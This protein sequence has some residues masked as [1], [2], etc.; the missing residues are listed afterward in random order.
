MRK[1]YKLFQWMGSYI[2]M[3]FANGSPTNDT[4][5]AY[6][7][8]LNKGDHCGFISII[9][10]IDSG[11][12]VKSHGKHPGIKGKTSYGYIQRPN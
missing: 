4:K 12:K 11:N 3:T 7:N 5:N 10:I 6:I 9:N 2:F 8:D 1:E